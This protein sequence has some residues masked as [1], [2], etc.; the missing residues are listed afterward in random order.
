MS[1]QE[2]SRSQREHEAA[3]LARVQER[4]KLAADRMTQ[5]RAASLLRRAAHSIGLARLCIEAGT[6]KPTLAA[7][8]ERV[9]HVRAANT[10]PVPPEALAVLKAQ[11]ADADRSPIAD[12]AAHCCARGKAPSRA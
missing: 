3:T 2:L 11:G 8:D 6:S 5:K 1:K 12:I 9:V 7:I 10:K 4:L